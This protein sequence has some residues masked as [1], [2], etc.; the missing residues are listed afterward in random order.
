MNTTLYKS[1]KEKIQDNI[2]IEKS[3][4]IKCWICL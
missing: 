4:K 2:R 1:E 3:E